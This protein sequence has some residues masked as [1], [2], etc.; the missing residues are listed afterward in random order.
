MIVTCERNPP[1]HFERSRRGDH[2]KL[3]VPRSR[4]IEIPWQIR[5]IAAEAA[6]G[7]SSSDD[8]GSDPF[9]VPAITNKAQTK[10]NTKTEKEVQNQRG[11]LGN[12]ISGY[13]PLR[14]DFEV[15]HDNNAE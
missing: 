14:G 9:A 5:S 4:Q 10:K 1:V 8:L 6:G 2:R 15:E 11:M 13:L 3:Q 12:D 7:G